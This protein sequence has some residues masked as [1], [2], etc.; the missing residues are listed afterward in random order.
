MEHNIAEMTQ[1]CI[2]TLQSIEI[3]ATFQNMNHMM[4]VL[5]TLEAIRKAAG[6]AGAEPEI[7][8]EV[9]EVKA[10]SDERG[11]EHGAD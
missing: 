8:V 5:Q 6:G 2:N 1:L 7:S 9:K 11:D 10:D 3:K 4:A